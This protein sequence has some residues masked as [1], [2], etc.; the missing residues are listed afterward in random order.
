MLTDSSYMLFL[1]S[2][3]LMI[4]R[5]RLCWRI[6]LPTLSGRSSESTTP[7]RKSNQRGIK[8]SNLSLINTLFTYNLMDRADDANMSLVSS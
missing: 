3:C 4:R 5:D 2:R 7:R 1:T 6:S 8:S